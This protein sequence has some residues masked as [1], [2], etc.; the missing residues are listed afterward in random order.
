MLFVNPLVMHADMISILDEPSEPT[1]RPV[2]QVKD[3][4]MSD[5]SR[6]F[7]ARLPELPRGDDGADNPTSTLATGVGCPSYSCT[8]NSTATQ[9]WNWAGASPGWLNPGTT[10]V[11]EGQAG[12]FPA[13]IQVDDG[14]LKEPGDIIIWR[15]SDSEQSSDPLRIGPQTTVVPE[16]SS[17][18]LLASFVA[19]VLVIPLTT[20]LRAGRRP[21]CRRRLEGMERRGATPQLRFGREHSGQPQRFRIHSRD[22]A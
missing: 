17:L 12:A 4:Q 6:K 8:V 11:S 5:T 19:F 21:L 7:H 10:N 13:T 18:A 22:L 16:P 20:Y 14:I 15:D 3:V 1:W 9:D 2:P